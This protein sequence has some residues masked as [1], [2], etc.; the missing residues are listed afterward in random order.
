[1]IDLHCH[2]LPGLDDGPKTI[3]ES[4]VMCG[5]AFQ[6]GIRTLV[7]MPHTLNGVY[8]NDVE[9]I[10]RAVEVLRDG[11][12]TAGLE[13]EIIPGSEVHVSPDIS[14][15][16]QDGQVMTINN[17]GQAV[18]LEFPEY[19]VPQIMCRFLE[20][21]VK[22]EIVPV[23]SHPERNT[24]LRDFDL[25][26]EMVQLGALTQVTAMSLTGEFSPEIQD[27]T[28]SLLKEGL[29]HVI[30]SDA[31]SIYHRPPVLSRAVAEASQILG[32]ERAISLVMANPH[33]IMRGRRPPAE[34]SRAAAE[35]DLIRHSGPP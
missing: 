25:V 31:H 33:L 6:D 7:A 29:V 17:T 13:M 11:L 27:F 32:K 20:S 8:S 34:L 19:F 24:Q 30:A 15:L 10:L 21:L 26:R 5:M 23:V 9:T 4:L 28:R 22:E 14:R 12:R 1:M 2:I 3:E 16:I 35:G 18:M